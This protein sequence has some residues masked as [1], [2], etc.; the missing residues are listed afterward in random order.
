M[1]SFCTLICSRRWQ[2][3]YP[4]PQQQQQQSEGASADNNFSSDTLEFTGVVPEDAEGEVLNSGDPPVVYSP[5]EPLPAPVALPAAAEL[6]RLWR[7]H[8]AWARNVSWPSLASASAS[9]ESE[10]ESPAVANANAYAADDDDE[11]ECD[12]GASIRT[13]WSWN[14]ME[15]E[16]SS[17][18]SAMMRRECAHLAGFINANDAGR[19]HVVHARAHLRDSASDPMGLLALW[20]VL[21]DL[22]TALL[23]LAAEA[24]AAAAAAARDPS[25]REHD[26]QELVRRRVGEA[27][28][29]FENRAGEVDPHAGL[30]VLEALLLTHPELSPAAALR[31]QRRELVLL[32]DASGVSLAS[33][34]ARGGLGRLFK[35]LDPMVKAAAGSVLLMVTAEGRSL[36]RVGQL[37]QFM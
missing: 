1:A 18:S 26:G 20:E 5:G 7:P 28:T 27:L 36:L 2:R 14:G 37:A 35:L 32:V 31:P 30:D 9:S 33:E 29:T 24:A 3:R 8:A 13:L 10:S 12:D 4:I 34:H 16:Q 22:I 15:E 21:H 17:S 25:E 19:S 23:P 6:L 11:G